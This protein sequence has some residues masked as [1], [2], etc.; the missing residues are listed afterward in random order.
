MDRA[1]KV[2]LSFVE[3]KIIWTRLGMSF[4][5]IIM[6]YKYVLNDTVQK[7]LVQSKKFRL[8][9]IW[10]YLHN[11]QAILRSWKKETAVISHFF[12]YV[13][14]FKRFLNFTHK[15][16]DTLAFILSCYLNNLNVIS[17]FP[18]FS[19]TPLSFVLSD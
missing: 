9:Q 16:H 17:N 5:K 12:S 8:V 19:L 14:C 10:T 18:D 1:Q 3:T 7:V 13:F 6:K 11:D 4:R 15:N 2:K